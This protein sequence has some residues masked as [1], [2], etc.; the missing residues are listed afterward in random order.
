M[1]DDVLKE[2][3]GDNLSVDGP[4]PAKWD[5]LLN[6]DLGDPAKGKCTTL[7][8]VLENRVLIPF[9]NGSR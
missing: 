2:F 4:S 9:S 1:H 6:T 3:N 5:R 8:C 7:K